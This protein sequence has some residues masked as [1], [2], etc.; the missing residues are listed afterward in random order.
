MRQIRRIIIRSQGGT[1]KVM[2]GYLSKPEEHCAYEE[3]INPN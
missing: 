2:E 3:A 1:E